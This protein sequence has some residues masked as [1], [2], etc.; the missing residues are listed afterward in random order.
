[1]RGKIVKALAGFYYV[2]TDGEGVYACKAKGLFRHENITPLVGDNVVFE[3]T[4]ENDMEGNVTEILERRNSL[5]R[6][7][8]A[9]ID[10]AL[11]VFAARHPDPHDN[12]LQ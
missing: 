12:M 2:D 10:Q 6:P 9:N 11:V 3:V 1:M 4:D 8:S 7:A 5:I